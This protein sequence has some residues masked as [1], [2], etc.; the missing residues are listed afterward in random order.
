MRIEQTTFQLVRLSEIAEIQIG[1]TPARKEPKFWGGKNTWVSISDLNGTKYIEN[2]KESISDKGIAGSGIKAVPKNTLI[3][4]FKLSIGKVA[5][6]KKKLYT[7]EAIAAFI[8]HDESILDLNYFY[9]LM[10]E[11]EFGDGGDRAVMGKTLN[12]AKLKE[13][14]I[15][16]PP[17]EEQKKIAEILDVAE[18]LKQ[19]DM[20]LI[21]KY[22]ELS[23][24]LFLDMFGDPAANP[25][26]WEKREVSTLCKEIVDCINRTAKTVDYETKYKM[27]RTTNVRNYTIDTSNVRYVDEDTYKS[28]TRRLKPSKGDVIFTREAP[29]GEAGI[30]ESEDDVFLGQRTM[31]FRCEP[32][33]L[34]PYY[35]LYELMGSGI[36]SQ[37]DKLSTGST[38]K[39]LSV[40]ACKKFKINVPPLDVQ[41]V[42]AQRVQKIE[43][44]KKLAHKSLK[45]SKE[46]FN[47]LL[48]RAFKGELTG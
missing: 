28:W 13:L 25:K 29:L 26:D 44:Q 31:Q 20:L 18:S 39:H 7:N 19:K 43:V 9:Y 23:Q 12:K 46:L 41:D 2:T 24:S 35:L 8:L 16:L 11:F 22:N 42:F 5:I 4:S 30:L 27:I 45:N 15:P 47:S 48:H 37:I 3:F 36:K 38:V 10:R 1:K 6:T 40:P 21:E 34:N 32:T 33:M 14:K 17:I